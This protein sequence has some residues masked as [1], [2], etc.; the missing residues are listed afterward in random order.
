VS[1]A[2]ADIEILASV[3]ADG[4]VAN[5]RLRVDA[6]FSLGDFLNTTIATADPNHIS[7]SA[8]GS[9]VTVQGDVCGECRLSVPGCRG[10]WYTAADMKPKLLLD[11]AFR[12]TETIF[13]REDL[14]RIDAVTE[15]LWAKDEPI[16][17][18]DLDAVAPEIEILVTGKWRHGDVGRFRKL[19]AILEVGGGFPSP[20]DLDYRQCFERGIR[21]LSCAPAFGPA[22]AEMALGLSLAAARQIAFTDSRFRS[23]E[24]QWSHTE[25]DTDIGTPFTL[26]GKQVG[27]IGFGGL[28]RSLRPLLAP[29]GCPIQ[30]FDPWLTDTF[31][32]RQGVTPVDI[33]TL[34]ST[35]RLIYVLAVPS[36]AN[37]AF[38]D[39]SALERIRPDA[40]LLLMSRAHVVDFHALTEMLLAGRFRAAIDVFPE[41]PIS[42]GHPIRRAEHA[43]LSSHRA[44]ANAEALHAVGRLVA[45]DVEALAA[46][47]VPYAMQRAEPE[48]IR[49]RG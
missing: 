27:F 44:G 46:G 4:D 12:K 42:Q 34:L 43:V 2:G 19:R 36:A 18:R 9:G 16:A 33:D 41:E 10:A 11:P 22:V 17:D 35:S 37:R 45:D 20:E 31:L 47:F 23:G 5:V 26:Y 14:A 49:L 7:V 24:P 29:F 48:Y 3:G 13:T 38:L 15:V 21:V 28:A 6:G 25:F 40:V 32:S 30:V 8:G 39:R 1:V